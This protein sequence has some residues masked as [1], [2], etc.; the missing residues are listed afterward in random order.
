MVEAAGEW[1][2]LADADLSMPMDE[3]SRFLPGSGRP[4][5][6]I[7]IGSREAAGAT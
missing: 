6:D 7:L 3:L 4:T 1:R 5:A 2:F